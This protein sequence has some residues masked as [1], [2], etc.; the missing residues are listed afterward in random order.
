MMNLAPWVVLVY[1]LIILSGGIAGF[2]AAHSWP[3]IIMGSLSAVLLVCAAIAMFKN[4]V[5]GYFAAVGIAFVLTVFFTNRFLH[6]FK[7]WPG[8]IMAIVSFLI[9][10]FLVAAKLKN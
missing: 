9:F 8:G 1:A 3:S 10:V 5:L 6:T 4:S 7:L 2:A